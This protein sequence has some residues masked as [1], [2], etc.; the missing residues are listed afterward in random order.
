L[1]IFVE[2]IGRKM[3]ELSESLRDVMRGWPTGV[4]VV[5]STFDGQSH[6]MTVNS[7]ASVSLDPPLIVVSLANQ[8]RTWNLVVASH[9]FAVT[10]LDSTQQ[11]ISDIFAGK[12]SEEADR[13]EGF[14]TFTLVTGAPLLKAGRAYLDCTVM[15]SVLVSK[16]TL[17]IGQVKVA[18]GDLTRAPLV[19]LNREYHQLTL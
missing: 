16:S 3:A 5:T 1:T 17:F 18:Q 11:H 15:Q 13:F 7:L 8:T 9:S 6:G 14:E 10:M 4:A 12:I 19:Y 2:F